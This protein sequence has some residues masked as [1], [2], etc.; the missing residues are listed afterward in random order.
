MNRKLIALLLILALVLPAAAG[1]GTVT[2]LTV[3]PSGNDD[4]DGISAPLATPMKALEL[5]KEYI[6][7]GDV[8]IKL[9]SG[10]YS[11]T[12]PLIINGENTDGMNGHTLTLSGEAGTVLSGGQTVANWTSEGGNVWSAPVDASEVRGLY[13]D[14]V[15]MK[16][17]EQKLY[18]SF[19]RLDNSHGIIK[20]YGE[21]FID[22]SH[23]GNVNEPVTELYFTTFRLKK[24]SYEELK[25]DLPNIR[26]RYDQTF[27]RSCWSV[28][29]IMQGQDAGQYELKFTQETLD[30]INKVQMADYNAFYDK[31]F[32][33]GSRL[34]LDKEGE[35]CFVPEEQK[36]Y[37][38]S[39]TD[40]NGSEC[41]IPV[42]RRLIDI[43]GSYKH[44]TG[45]IR[46]ENITFT[47]CAEPYTATGV[48]KENCCEHYA[49][50][51]DG[52]F[53]RL[54]K[55]EGSILMNN[56]SN[57]EIASCAFTNLSV[58]AVRLYERVYNTVI[59]DCSF[60]NLSMSGICAG[61]GDLNTGFGYADKYEAPADY[62]NVWEL[63]KKSGV[64]PCLLTID[65]NY[66]A[67]IGLHSISGSGIQVDYC[68]DLTV[69]R[70]TFIDCAA[71]GMMLGTGC[72]NISVSGIGVK[73]NG[74]YT[75]KN[76]YVSHSNRTA[77]DAAGIYIVGFAGKGSIITDNFVDMTGSI[78]DDN[79]AYYL[80][81][82]SEYVTV[83]HNMSINTEHW[84]WCRALPLKFNGSKYVGG[85]KLEKNTIMNCAV[86]GNFADRRD[87]GAD[88]APGYRWP[89]AAEV[90][91]SNV[92]VEEAKIVSDWQNDPEIMTIYENA[93]CT[94]MSKE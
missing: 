78:A 9:E 58:T 48:Y 46:I 11:I 15:P 17:A 69:T 7:T 44:L 53:V 59:R 12:E 65:N 86:Y 40:P 45:D 80:D 62:T 43:S 94:W 38:Y 18:G 13:V 61:H 41:V 82:G 85:D 71:S 5:A 42:A 4:N 91:G 25:K 64:Q 32:L 10:V 84:L 77:D 24:G 93:G 20:Q 29:D 92:T 3:S 66:F 31:A 73:Y 54:W 89:S 34:F 36:L 33:Y 87:R 74:P 50:K 57:I 70:N 51:E 23:Y 16:V 2:V 19:V 52:V 68:G 88:Y 83:T 28:E 47:H 8:T 6:F 79:P 1:E 22:W 90:K 27:M 37:Y 60:T 39:E 30:L 76:N 72:N 26:F 75:V 21:K 63:P 49:V 35:Y 56:A 81:E 67:H 55:G 14:G